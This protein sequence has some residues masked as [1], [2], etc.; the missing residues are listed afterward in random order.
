MENLGSLAILLA[1]SMAIYAV[2]ASLVGR[3][4][5]K[6][7]L[8][9][10]GER[11]VYAVWFLISVAAAVLVGALLT[12]DF[13]FAYVAE[14]SNRAMPALYKFAAW[15][16]GQEGSLLLWSWLLATYS[17]VVAFTN[18]RRHRD[19]M[20]YVIAVLMTVQTFFL[21]LNAFVA[22][23]FKV[24]SLD[25]RITAV[26]DGN[27]LSPLLQYP[28]M[29]IHPPMLY[30]GYVGFAVPFAF[31]IGSL[32]TRQAGDGWIHTT[33]RWTLVTWL[34]QSTG[35]MLGMAWAYHVLG[36]GGYWGWDPVENASLLPWLSG[37]AFLHSVMMQEKKGMMKVWNM[38]LISATFFLCIL[39]TFLTRSGV[40]QSVHAFAR[41]EIGKYFV[42]FMAIGIAATV[43]LILERLDYLKSESQLESVVSRESSFLFNNLILL[44][45]CFA[46][47]WGTLFPV[48]SA[49]VSNNQ[50]S[51]DA[52]W[53]NRLMV[54]IGLFL[55]FLT[56]VGPLFSWRRTSLESLRRNFQWPG[57]AAV[58]LVG[59]L[60]AAGVRSY[61]ALISF[62]FCLFVALTVFMEF[63]KGSKSI[64]AKNGMNLARAAVELTHRN[65]RRYGGYVVH[66]GIV[67]MFIG[68]TGQAFNL[69]DT[70]ELNIG[71]SM[72]I[73]RYDLKMVNLEQG[74]N[75][76]YQWHRATVDV[77]KDG[78]ELGLLRPEKRFFQASRQST[79]EVGIRVRPNEDVYLNFGA[80]SD[81]NQ[82]A[83][84]QAYINPLVSWVWIGGLVLIGGTLIC[85][86]PAK[87]KMQY[88]RTQVVG[89]T[90]KH[91][92]VPK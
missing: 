50:I 48:T 76:N 52:D 75:A 18:R 8:I 89:V 12:G 69:K 82:R 41:S 28:A 33:R 87:I 15:W 55:L 47:L 51:L 81:D 43:Y 22:T 79:S 32:I 36:W 86:V 73:G 65:T 17:S 64:A 62:G 67:L 35:V 19:F 88:A 91:A 92:T 57:A 46:V 90:G 20:P 71:D 63:Y 37:T 3:L 54:P 4:K 83:V 24:L 30:L 80:M 39:G 56:G 16:G 34:F 9:V 2:L 29:A 6:P 5:Q 58:V 31:A 61:Y 27:G 72:K 1:F 60:I 13:R 10:S 53:Y 77:Y 68:F 40:V 14:H 23:P 84:I 74:E 78:Q 70:R 11:A 25:G 66:M 45:S 49:L 26:P 85:L 38:V 21:V 59:A 7:F 42:T 44:A